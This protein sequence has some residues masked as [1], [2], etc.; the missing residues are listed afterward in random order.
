MEAKRNGLFSYEQKEKFIG[1]VKAGKQKRSEI[2][3][4]GMT[5]KEA[6]YYGYLDV[7]RAPLQGIKQFVDNTV[8]SRNGCIEEIFQYCENTLLSAQ[9]EDTF[10]KGHEK[11]CE[12][13]KKFYNDRGYIDFTVGKA[14]KWINMALKYACIYDNEDAEKLQGIFQYCHVPIDRYVANPIVNELRVDLPGYSGFKMPK[15]VPFDAEKCNYSWSKIDDYSDY[16]ACQKSIRE[17][18]RKKSPAQCALEWEFIEW[19]CEKN[20]R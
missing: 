13:I 3:E 9:S 4:K 19:L 5:L 14:Q 8:N 11:L 1:S 20:N 10:D 6:F 2:L 12:I 17:V 18:L 7:S 16:L 15:C